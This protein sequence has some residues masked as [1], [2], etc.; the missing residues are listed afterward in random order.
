MFF[1]IAIWTF[2]QWYFIAFDLHFPNDQ[3]CWASFHVL[4]G[5]VYIIFGSV[6]VQVLC[7]GSN[8]IGLCCWAVGMLHVSW[9]LTPFQVCKHLLQLSVLTFHSVA[10]FHAQKFKVS[11]RSKQISQ[12]IYHLA[13]LLCLMYSWFPFSSPPVFFWVIYDVISSLPLTH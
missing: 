1:M 6:C 2:V 9:L 10:P 12:S 4:A 5:H 7:P 13:D 3:R 11:M 8:L